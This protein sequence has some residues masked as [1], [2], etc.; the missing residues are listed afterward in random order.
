M[1]AIETKD[2]YFTLEE[3]KREHPRILQRN[4]RR[5]LFNGSIGHI[6]LAAPSLY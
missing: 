2:S 6:G 3:R 5:S 4:Y 1:K